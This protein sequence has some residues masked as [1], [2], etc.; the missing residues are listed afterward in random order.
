[1]NKKIKKIIIATGGTGGHIFPAYSLAKH[2]IENEADVKI[3]SDKRGLKYLKD[4]DDIKVVE[5]NSSPVFK[6]NIFKLLFSILT[7][8]YSTFRSFIFLMINKPNLVFGMGGYSSFPVCV[9]ATILR[10]PFIIYENNLHIGKANRYLLPYAK[11]IFV[12]IRELE[13]ISE[14]Y[15]KKIYVIGNIIRKEILNF[16][17]KTNSFSNSKKLKI[18]VL[19]GSQAAK[20]FAEKLPKIFQ[21]CNESKISFKIYQQC[22]FEQN[23][24]LT[25]FYKNLNIDFEI[26]NFSN[27][28]LDYFSKVNL[29]ITRSGSSMLAELVNAKIPFISVPLPSSADNHQLKNAIYYKKKGYSYLIEERDLN[30]KLFQLLEKINEDITLLDQIII[31]QRQYSDK[32]VYENIDKKIKMIIN[33]EY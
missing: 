22:L 15:N 27:N 5:I 31:K 21:K 13:G 26:F 4:Y 28:I 11:K 6:K 17:A 16:Q 9:A 7:I 10:I 25:S 29:A 2:F 18:L 24:F 20:I 32:S 14:K 12:S 1:M 33:E 8:L 23:E 19:G 3:I 30:T